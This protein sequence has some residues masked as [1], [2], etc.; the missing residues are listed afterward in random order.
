MT[1]CEHSEGFWDLLHL[2]WKLLSLTWSLIMSNSFIF[3]N[4]RYSSGVW[5]FDNSCKSSQTL[6]TACIHWTFS[7]LVKRQKIWCG[8]SHNSSRILQ[9][10]CIQWMSEKTQRQ[11]CRN[12]RTHV[13]ILWEQWEWHHFRIRVDGGSDYLPSFRVISCYLP[14]SEKCSKNSPCSHVREMYSNYSDVSKISQ[15]GRQ[16]QGG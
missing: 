14:G 8:N 4:L 9:T 1:F 12:C 15:R 3:V 6:E 2:T 5:Y 13:G 16:P 7:E 11:W 10:A